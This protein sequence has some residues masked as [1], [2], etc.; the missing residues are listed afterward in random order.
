MLDRILRFIDLVLITLIIGAV[1]TYLL[2]EFKPKFF[3]VQDILTLFFGISL[4]FGCL[5]GIYDWRTFQYE[6]KGKTIPTSGVLLAGELSFSVNWDV[7]GTSP[8]TVIEWGTLEPDDTANV[9]LWVKNEASVSIYA[10]I[11]WNEESWDPP[12]AGQYFDLTWNFGETSLGSNRARKVSLQL[13][14]H[15]DITEITDFSFDIVITV[16]DQPFTG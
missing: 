16:D 12:G 13:H 7:T 4:I 1:V 10:K 14:V 6:A 5:W 3:G 9:I 11:E 15:Q 8:A 2:F